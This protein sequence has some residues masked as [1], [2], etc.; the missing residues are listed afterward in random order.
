MDFLQ[1]GMCIDIV[2]ICFGIANRQ[3]WPVF[4]RVMTV[5]NTSV[6]L[7]QNKNFSL[8][9]WIFTKF[10]MYIDIV[11]IWLGIAHWQISSIFD[12]IYLQHDNGRVLSFH[13]CFYFILSCNTVD[14]HYLEL[15]YLE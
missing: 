9:R 14:S 5:C 11:D 10:D 7:F 13:F 2:E 1:L 4:D 12:I 3:T 8:S 6:S 15:T